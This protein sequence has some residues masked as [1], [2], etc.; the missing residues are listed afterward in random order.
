[1][2]VQSIHLTDFTHFQRGFKK[3]VKEIINNGVHPGLRRDNPNYDSISS[4]ID[5]KYQEMANEFPYAFNLARSEIQLNHLIY[6][7]KCTFSAWKP[8]YPNIMNLYKW[9]MKEYGI[10]GRNT[11][12]I[13]ASMFLPSSNHIE[14]YNNILRRSGF[15]D[16][17]NKG[18]LLNYVIPTRLANDSHHFLQFPFHFFSYKNFGNF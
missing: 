9:F 13:G 4:G 1:M 15:N 14:S 5:A 6:I 7:M 17:K 11:Y 18:K 2:P 16:K 3:K 8:R 10:S 12:Y